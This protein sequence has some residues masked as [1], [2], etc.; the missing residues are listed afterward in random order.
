MR[1]SG[2]WAFACEVSGKWG[3]AWLSC[4]WLIV[5]C[6]WSWQN[7]VALISDVIKFCLG[8]GTCCGLTIISYCNDL[9]ILM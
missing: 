5:C 6:G 4:R 8:G 2:K 7:L 9:L 3:W 1:T